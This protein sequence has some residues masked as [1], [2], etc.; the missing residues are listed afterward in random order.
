MNIVFIGMRATGKTT[1][2]TG[3]AKRC[4]R[5]CIETDEEIVNQA[6]E[7]DLEYK[8]RM[9]REFGIDLDL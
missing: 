2:A 6:A 9:K 8:S 4:N 7:T 3:L 5:R 1:I